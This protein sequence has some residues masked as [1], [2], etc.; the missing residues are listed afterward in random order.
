MEA[1]LK[2]SDNGREKLQRALEESQMRQREEQ[3]RAAKYAE[4]VLQENKRLSKQ[5]AVLNEMLQQRES[6]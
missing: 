2:T 1:H 5:V 6:E 4:I 3:E